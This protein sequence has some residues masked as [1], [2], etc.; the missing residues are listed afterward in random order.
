VL[1]N[2]NDQ[3]FGISQLIADVTVDDEFS[4]ITATINK[5]PKSIGKHIVENLSPGFV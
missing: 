3:D 2:I 4:S 1:G 5:I